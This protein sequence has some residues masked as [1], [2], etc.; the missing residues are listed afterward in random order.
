MPIYVGSGR[1]IGSAVTVYTV[2]GL[3]AMRHIPRSNDVPA[4]PAEL[5]HVKNGWM[6]S[7]LYT[8]LTPKTPPFLSYYAIRSIR[9]SY[10]RFSIQ[11]SNYISRFLW[12]MPPASMGK[13]KAE[14]GHADSGV[15]RSHLQR[16]LVQHDLA[17]DDA[18]LR[19]EPEPATR[20][21]L[22][23]TRPASARA[24]VLTAR[25][26]CSHRAEAEAARTGGD[27][28]EGGGRGGERGGGG[29][30]HRRRHACDRGG[31]RHVDGQGAGHGTGPRGG[32]GDQ[33]QR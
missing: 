4:L 26:S 33:R 22:A 6:E 17:V 7:H 23:R 13:R 25:V 9:A 24:R 31:A 3:R 32:G 1:H 8:Y 5:L 16:R 27:T 2:R 12:H 20:A 15:A 19:R 11:K 28:G 21:P 30:S 10:I 29:R 14:P 18:Q